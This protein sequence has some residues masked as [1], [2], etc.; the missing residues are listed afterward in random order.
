MR[1]RP[2]A[3]FFCWSSLAIQLHLELLAIATYGDKTRCCFFLLVFA[4]HPVTPWAPRHRYLWGQGQLLFP[5]FGLCL[6]S[7]HVLRYSPSLPMKT[8]P[9]ASFFRWSSLAIQL[10]LELLAI[11][12]YGN[13]AS[14]LWFPVLTLTNLVSFTVADIMRYLAH[15][16]N[17]FCLYKPFSKIL[18]W[19]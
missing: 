14:C 3:T 8:R 4:R 18:S 11:A 15:S 2:V 10:H 6:P 5:F 19:W 13:K 7:S 9:V 12:T 17:P 1:T 16:I